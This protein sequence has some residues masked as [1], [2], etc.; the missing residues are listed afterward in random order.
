M[1]MSAKGRKALSESMK[2]RWRQ[3]HAENEA[4]NS[5]KATTEDRLEQTK[6]L[7][8]LTARIEQT[9]D[10]GALVEIYDQFNVAQ[11]KLR[12]KLKAKIEELEQI[13]ARVIGAGPGL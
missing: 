11:E 3:R 12:D 2:R 1:P 13:K 9:T 4:I 5:N 10:F 6:V 7:D 8:F